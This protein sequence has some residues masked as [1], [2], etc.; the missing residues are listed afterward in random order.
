MPPK[1]PVT[2]TIPEKFKE[3]LRAEQTKDLR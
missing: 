2:F 3:K 1:P